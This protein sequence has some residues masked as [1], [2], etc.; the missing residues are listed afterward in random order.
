[1]N[2]MNIKTFYRS[3]EYKVSQL[4]RG[5]RYNKH[6]MDDL[7]SLITRA[8]SELKKRNSNGDC[9]DSKIHRSIDKKHK[10]NFHIS[11]GNSLLASK[12]NSPLRSMKFSKRNSQIFSE[13]KNKL[14][15]YKFYYQIGFGGFGRVWK[16]SNK[17]T[18]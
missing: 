7:T 1:M 11:A 4:V 17:E 9:E 15:S 18:L 10:Q 16:V 3:P 5:H 13:E 12:S 2:R 8:P 14:K 6:S